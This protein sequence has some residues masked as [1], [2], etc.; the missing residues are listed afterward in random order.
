MNTVFELATIEDAWT[1]TDI[2]IGL[3][4]MNAREFDKGLTLTPEGQAT[5]ME[6]VAHVIAHPDDGGVLIYRDK[7]KDIAAIS[8][9]RIAGGRGIASHMWVRRDFRGKGVGEALAKDSLAYLRSKGAKMINA[10]IAEGNT[11][12]HNLLEKLGGRRLVA[13]YHFDEEK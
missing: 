2:A 1:V 7:K 6:L 13:T 12:M 9:L 3:H 10:E 4:D 8:M 5:I 11:V